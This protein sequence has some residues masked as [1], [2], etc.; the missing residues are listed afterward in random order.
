MAVSQTPHRGEIKGKPVNSAARRGFSASIPVP[1]SLA[2]HRAEAEALSPLSQA[3]NHLSKLHG[4]NSLGHLASVLHP[5]MI[6]V[7]S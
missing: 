4:V 2:H 5:K 1:R 7:L 6:V 3:T